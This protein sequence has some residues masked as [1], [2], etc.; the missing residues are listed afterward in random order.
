MDPIS[1]DS[2]LSSEELALRERVHRPQ[3]TLLVPE[4]GALRQCVGF[5]AMTAWGRSGEWLVAVKVAGCGDACLSL[6]RV[7]FVLK[8][9][10]VN[11]GQAAGGVV[12]DGL[13]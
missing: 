7:I 10:G 13:H 9:N 4:R 1:F 5:T 11:P 8:L 2:L 12:C 6:R 3:R